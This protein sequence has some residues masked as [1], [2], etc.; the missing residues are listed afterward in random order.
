[1]YVILIY[2]NEYISL[3]TRGE[4]AEVFHT[5]DEA[6]EMVCHLKKTEVDLFGTQDIAY[7]IVEVK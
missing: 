7:Q 2:Y 6:A 3:Y 1:M 5:A 4:F